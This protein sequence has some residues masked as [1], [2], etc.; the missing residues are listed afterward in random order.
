M[1]RISGE[2]L[3]SRYRRQP[4]AWTTRRSPRFRR[5]AELLASV[6]SSHVVTIHTIEAHEGKP[7]LTMEYV[8]GETLTERIAEEGL[9]L[10]E[11]LRTPAQ[12]AK[13]LEATHASGVIHRDLKPSNVKMTAG[14]DVK[15]LD[16]GLARPVE[17]TSDLSSA[18]QVMGTPAY[19]SPEQARGKV[20][21]ER[22][23][24]WA[25][26]G[27]VFECLPGK[28]SFRGGSAAEVLSAILH[29]EP[30]WAALPDA[31]PGPVR[32]LLSHCLAKKP[33]VIA[34]AR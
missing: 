13:A 28:Q 8:P 30:D 5:E 2:R 12:I 31:T 33:D 20:L 11:L 24:V 9:G 6:T 22:T 1:I 17:I 7:F 27:T 3:Q 34:F 32:T 15:V 23:D 18:G 4:S 10:T 14:G 25:L 29:D 26:G 19:M 16:F 21:D